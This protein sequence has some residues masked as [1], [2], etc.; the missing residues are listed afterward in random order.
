MS[1]LFTIVEKIIFL[2][3][4]ADI[5]DYNGIFSKLQTFF[6]ASSYKKLEKVCLY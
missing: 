3:P 5:W 2:K 6:E 4:Y 1:I